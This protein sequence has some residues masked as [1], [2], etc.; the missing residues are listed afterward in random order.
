MIRGTPE[1]ILRYLPDGWWVSSHTVYVKEVATGMLQ[2]ISFS[3]FRIYAVALKKPSERARSVYKSILST[4]PMHKG[5]R[6]HE[7]GY[8]LLF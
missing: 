6:L 3:A 5:D 8:N 7:K 1:E 4:L 2:S